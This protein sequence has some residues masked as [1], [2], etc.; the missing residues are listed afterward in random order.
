MI[1]LIRLSVELTHNMC[2]NLI[3]RLMLYYVHSCLMC[4]FI[5]FFSAFGKFGC[6]KRFHNIVGQESG[7]SSHRE[8]FISDPTEFTCITYDRSTII[9]PQL[10][11]FEQKPASPEYSHLVNGWRT[12]SKYFIYSLQLCSWRLYSAP[13]AEFNKTIFASNNFIRRKNRC[14][15]GK[16]CW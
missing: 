3:I 1:L 7:I 4:I 2:L 8:L 5:L 13:T 12:T 15:F 9:L 14:A 11:M 10:P 16:F 6:N